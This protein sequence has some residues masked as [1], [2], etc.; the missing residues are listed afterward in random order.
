[1]SAVALQSFGFGD[2]LVR[3]MDRNGGVWFVANDVCGALELSN[4]R[5]SVKALDDDQRDDVRITDAIGRHQSTTI[6]SESGVYSLIFKSRKPSAVA[7]RKWVT[8]SVLP[9]IRQTGRFEVAPAPP[10]EAVP[11]DALDFVE[12]VRAGLQMVREARIIFGLSAARRAWTLA[13]LPDVS[14]DGTLVAQ[15]LDAKVQTVAKWFAERVEIQTG[16]RESAARLYMDYAKYCDE[17][18]ESP[19]NMTS[20]GRT[21]GDLGIEKMRSSNVFYV[22]VRLKS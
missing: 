22:G 16:T 6:I 9:T 17:G 13:G 12:R 1:M 2:Q 5:V 11:V 20:F 21:M 7:F 14:D 3:V 8:G 4:A 19:V 10:P 15:H 18:G